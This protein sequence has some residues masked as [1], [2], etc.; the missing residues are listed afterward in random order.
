MIVFSKEWVGL[1][2][3]LPG[4]GGPFGMSLIAQPIGVCLWA[5]YGGG[6]AGCCIIFGA[7]TIGVDRARW[8]IADG[9]EG[10]VWLNG[11]NGI[12]STVVGI[13]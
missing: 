13:F 11:W 8:P 7:A 4:T 10:G 6:G 12:R 1:F 9:A 5:E 3:L 2:F